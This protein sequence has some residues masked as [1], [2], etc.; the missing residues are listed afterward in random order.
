MAAIPKNWFSNGVRF[1]EFGLRASTVHI[2]VN[3]FTVIY[4]FNSIVRQLFKFSIV[5]QL[6]M[7]SIVRQLLMFSIVR[8]LFLLLLL[9][10]QLLNAG[11]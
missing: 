9:H 4:V 8:Q 3:F 1:S 11:E 5:R 7:F 10:R 2:S 6:L